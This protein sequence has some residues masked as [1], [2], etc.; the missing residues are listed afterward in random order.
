VTDE[1]R[2]TYFITAKGLPVSIGMENVTYSEALSIAGECM[3][4]GQIL[5]G[6]DDGPEGYVVSFEVLPAVK[7]TNR[8]PAGPAMEMPQELIN[9]LL[10]AAKEGQVHS[11]DERKP[12]NGSQES[13][14]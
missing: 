2:S 7:I 4:S 8:Q 1:E 13:R 5:I 12:A 11:P 14:S 10:L 3:A 9:E 6:P